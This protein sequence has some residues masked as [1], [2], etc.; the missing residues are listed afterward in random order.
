MIGGPRPRPSMFKP[1]VRH[2]RGAD[3]PAL[4]WDVAE[5]SPVVSHGQR[6]AQTHTQAVP[7]RLD[8][9]EVIGIGDLWRL[10]GHLPGRRELGSVGTRLAD[11]E[12]MH[13]A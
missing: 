9:P 8:L 12:M 11:W 5:T 7:R 4:R 1:R 2:G 6:N 13:Y 10:F 3:P